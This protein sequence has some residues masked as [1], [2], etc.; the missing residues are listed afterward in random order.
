MMGYKRGDIVIVNLNPKKGH[1]VGK[2]RPAVILSDDDTNDNLDTLIV[3]PLSTDLIDN[4]EPWRM[5][6]NARGGLRH[7][8]DILI[9]QIRTL[10]QQRIGEKIAE[11][12]PDEYARIVEALC[13]NFS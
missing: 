10:S 1:E 12:S 8:S 6:L 3:L 5:R 11:L 2:I 13:K 9:N 7:D 4:M